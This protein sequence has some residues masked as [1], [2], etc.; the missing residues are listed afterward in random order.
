MILAVI[1]KGSDQVLDQREYESARMVLANDLSFEAD[2]GHLEDLIRGGESER[3]EFKESFDGGDGW[4]RTVCAFSNGDGGVIFF[5]V[6]ND[7]SIVGL[8]A[9]KTADQIAQS[10]GA[11][12]EPFPSYR[13]LEVMVQGKRIVYIDVDGGSEKP[14][15]VRGR[16]VFVR[17]Q[18][19]SRQATRQELLVLAKA[20]LGDQ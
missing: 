2:G 10:I 8:A 14:Y 20:A 12:V 4:L 5:G 17:A 18:A 7:T 15:L 1:E 19:T 3:V 13:F 6:K 9:S 11:D 16:G